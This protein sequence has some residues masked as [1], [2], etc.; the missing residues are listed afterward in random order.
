MNI[1][2][3]KV[4]NLKISEKLLNFVNNDVLKDTNIESKEFWSGFDQAV[5]ELAPKNRELI[6]FR[7]NLQNKIDHWHKNNGSE[8]FEI[9]KYKKFLREDDFFFEFS[10]EFSKIPKIPTIL[11]ILKKTWLKGYDPDM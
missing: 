6:N 11:T 8:K 2:Y 4:G 9:N 5:H 10:V 7:Q 3:Q 1:K